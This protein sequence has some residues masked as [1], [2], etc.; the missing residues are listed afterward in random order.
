MDQAIS[1]VAI[2]A[3][4]PTGSIVDLAVTTAKRASS[5]PDLPTIDSF[6]KGFDI[7][8]WYAMFYPAGTPRPIVDKMN[9][10]I[11]K[12]LSAKDVESMARERADPVGS[13][14]VLGVIP[15]KFERLAGG[16]HALLEGI[17]HL[18][19]DANPK[20]VREGQAGANRPLF[21][22]E[23][24]RDLLP[25]I[26]EIAAVLSPHYGADCPVAIVYRATWPDEEIILTTLAGM[27]A[28]VRE[29][30]ITRTALIM[31]GRVL[32]ERRFRDSSLYDAGFAHVLR[33][34]GKKKQ[35]VPG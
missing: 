31:V 33:N 17:D 13:E 22:G 18:I 20:N 32:G 15:K 8:N 6:Y 30:K 3:P 16:L 5:L 11:K 27:R 35:R 10:E 14:G 26:P 23:L 24:P 1:G 2:R 25:S 29:E 4:V 21:L 28:R 34:A 9:A 12:A 7:D 19:V